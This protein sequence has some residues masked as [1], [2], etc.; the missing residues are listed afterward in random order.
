M[1]ANIGPKIQQRE[2]EERKTEFINFSAEKSCRNFLTDVY[3]ICSYLALLMFFANAID[4]IDPT[5]G[6]SE[7]LRAEMAIRPMFLSRY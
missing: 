1:V 4:K 6:N 5:R 3:A 2:K 7:K